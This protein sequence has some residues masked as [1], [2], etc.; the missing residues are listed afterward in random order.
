MSPLVGGLSVAR[1]DDKVVFP[2]PFTP[3]RL[4]ISLLCIDKEMPLRAFLA[5]KDFSSPCTC[6]KVLIE[7]FLKMI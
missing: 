1:I 3:K 6:N 5:P 2:A 4:I 7:K